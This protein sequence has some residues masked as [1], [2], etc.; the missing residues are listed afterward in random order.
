[1][2]PILLGRSSAGL[3]SPT[4]RIPLDHSNVNL[5]L[6]GVAGFFG[7]NVAVS[8][9]S[10]VYFRRGRKY[11]GWYNNAGSC[12]I[13]QRYGQLARWSFWDGLFPGEDTPP[14]IVFKLDGNDGPSFIGL[15]S[16]AVRLAKTG[17]IAHLLCTQCQEQR[18]AEMEEEE[19]EKEKAYIP[20]DLPFDAVVVDLSC[21]TLQKQNP[22]QPNKPIELHT[23]IGPWWSYLPP[24]LPILASAATAAACVFFDDWICF[25]MIVLGMMASGISCWMIGTGQIF[26]RQLDAAEETSPSRAGIL[27]DGDRIVVLKGPVET[28]SAI[29]HGRFELV[30][31]F[32]YHKGNDE[33]YHVLGISSC[34]LTV[35]FLAQLL[36]VPQGTFFGQIMFLVSLGCSWIYNCCVSPFSLEAQRHALFREVIVYPRSEEPSP[37]SPPSQTPAPSVFIPRFQ[38]ESFATRNSAIIFSLLMLIS[39]TTEGGQ[40]VTVRE[41]IL[42]KIIKDIFPNPDTC[43]VEGKKILAKEIVDLARKRNPAPPGSGTPPK[44]NTQV[45]E[46]K[47]GS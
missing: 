26:F 23:D 24:L 9:M 43:W 3:E 11:M 37:D 12:E 22:D 4:S 10:T 20:N 34:I 5:D 13:A 21:A 32:P 31:K 8:A 7:G 2:S 1:M 16:G 25:S 39:P 17:H 41:K 29:T 33:T 47:S 42:G 35:Q 45:E 30:Y 40:E 27:L 14:A 15:K 19:K 44:G 36:I 18:E 46:G 38:R 6:S 28:V